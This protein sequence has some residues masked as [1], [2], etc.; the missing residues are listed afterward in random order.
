[1]SEPPLTKS[2]SQ[3]RDLWKWIGATVAATGVAGWGVWLNAT[4]T[5]PMLL[6][7]EVA[8]LCI[9]GYPLAKS[10]QKGPSPCPSRTSSSQS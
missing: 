10:E 1:M 3:A 8:A 4:T 7:G 5:L 9:W 6:R 2:E